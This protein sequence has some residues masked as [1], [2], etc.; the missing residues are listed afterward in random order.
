MERR[1]KEQDR[2]RIEISVKRSENLIPNSTD[3]LRFEKVVSVRDDENG[4]LKDCRIAVAFRMEKPEGRAWK[5]TSLNPGQVCIYFPAVKE[6]SNLR[7]HLHAPFASTVARDSVRECSANT[8]LLNHLADLTAE[9]MS[10]IRDQG[11]LNVEFLAVLPNDKDNLSDDYLPIQKQLIKAFNKKKLTPMKQGGHAAASRSV[12]RG[13][14]QLSDL[15]QDG[16]L[17]KAP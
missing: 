15:I 11:L 9:S 4:E 13:R 16:D 10:A 5:I 2:N 8:E 17:A 3:Y 7:F 6:T 12:Y 14:L 1:E